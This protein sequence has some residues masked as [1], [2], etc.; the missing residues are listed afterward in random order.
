M[1]PRIL[2]TACALSLLTSGCAYFQ[3]NKPIRIS[4]DQN[5]PVRMYV[6]EKSIKKAKET[7][8]NQILI[9]PPLGIDD[10]HVQRRFQQQLYSAAQRRFTTPLAI[11]LADSAYKPYIE[12]SNLVRNDGLLN[13]EEVAIIGALMNCSYVIC[14]YI[15]ELKPYHPQRIDIR[16]VVVNA[17]NGKVSAELSSV[18]DA[19][20]N[21]IFDYFIEHCESRKNPDE[22]KDD[23]GL[24]I[25]S[26]AAFQAFVADMC[27]TVMAARLPF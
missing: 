3:K 4:T 15:R 6:Y 9:L 23:L 10:P 17:G 24:K 7:E 11:V 21:D 2:F 19:R 22:S 1:S 16:I 27:S 14:P 20:E 8:L 13:I 18:F 25:K 12:E 5:S 26:P